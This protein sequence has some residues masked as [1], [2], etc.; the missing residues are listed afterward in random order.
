MRR[1][2]ARTAMGD[3]GE[4]AARIV[5]LA[6]ETE[7]AWCQE[8]GAPQVPTKIREAIVEIVR[9]ACGVAPNTL[10]LAALEWQRRQSEAKGPRNVT[11][12]HDYDGLEPTEDF[13]QGGGG[14]SRGD[15]WEDDGDSEW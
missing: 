2:P 15:R 11:L 3:V 9:G 5:T 1:V 6:D 14:Y 8:R 13:C 4:W 12:A 7:R 10:R